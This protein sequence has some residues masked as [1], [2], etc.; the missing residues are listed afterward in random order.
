ML[1]TLSIT[2]AVSAT[3]AFADC[4][5]AQQP[6]MPPV[7][8]TAY[9]VL[10]EANPE[11][12]LP[13]PARAATVQRHYAYQFRLIA[14]GHT[15]LGGPLVP[16]AGAPFTGMTVLRAP[17]R[18]AAD[19]MAADD[20]AVQAG[21]LRATV[22]TWTTVRSSPAER[23]AADTITATVLEFFRAMAAADVEAS[24]L[25]LHPEGVRFA[26]GIEADGPWLRRQTNDAYLERL[27]T[28]RERVHEQIHDVH[29]HVRGSV[30][31]A[32]APYDFYVDG[33][34]THCGT[35]AITLVR[36]P[37]GWRIASS[38]WTVEATGCAPAPR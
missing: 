10:L 26:T 27:G 9:V 24:R 12:R 38:A 37:E 14:D 25:V 1:L 19:R 13:D 34:F 36:T 6:A 16:E 35:N 22:R 29:V 5:S 30:A 3:A 33:E 2:A 21:L 17:T 20:P 7:L 15:I 31:T 4:A 28:R 18:A 11:H 8:D 32:W 23:A